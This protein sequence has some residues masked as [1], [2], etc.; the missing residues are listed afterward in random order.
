MNWKTLMVILLISSLFILS[1]PSITVA[2]NNSSPNLNIEQTYIIEDKGGNLYAYY[3]IRISNLNNNPPQT[4]ELKFPKEF[5]GN[6]TYMY[7]SAYTKENNNLPIKLVRKNSYSSFEIT[8]SGLKV[9]NGE[10]NFK[11]IM[12]IPLHVYQEKMFEYMFKIIKYPAANL[13][14]NHTTVKIE[15]P[16][17]TKPDNLPEGLS[18]VQI[19]S[20]G[21][22]LKQYEIRGEFSLKDIIYSNGL[23]NVYTIT[24]KD[25]KIPY[26]QVFL[27]SGY[28]DIS[29]TIYPDGKIY[30]QYIYTLKNMGIDVFTKNNKLTLK[31]IENTVGV[32]VDSL[33]NRSLK[34]EESG[35]ILYVNLPYAVLSNKTLQFKAVYQVKGNISNKGLI[36]ENIVYNLP[37]EPTLDFFISKAT[38]TVEDPAGNIIDRNTYYNVTRFSDISLNGKTQINL[39]SIIRRNNY[40]GI[41]IY[42]IVLFGVS[43]TIYRGY[44]ILGYKKLP[45]E[46]KTFVAQLKKETVIMDNL[47]KLEDRYLKREIKGKQYLK[48]RA[49]LIKSLK[50]EIRETEKLKSGVKKIVKH[51]R[52]I[53]NILELAD[54]MRGKWNELRDLEEKFL[55]RKISPGEYTENRKTLLIEFQ[56]FIKK[57]EELI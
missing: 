2:A 8:T 15:I 34:Y 32:Y 41:V 55:N 50:K 43:L 23:P 28:E 29:I 38:V 53:D 39:F 11:F 18:L 25:L 24:L 1:M 31:K 17:N 36:G 57:I 42:T 37:I 6:N 20:A 4:I 52:R 49:E 13:P 30:Y 3:N 10:A 22:N 46:M 19:T 45:E 21:A 33:L 48:K 44:T 16:A 35:N 26:P 12:Y 51:N 27:F 9:V 40:I 54:D 7:F 47:I 5:T 14:I 56:A